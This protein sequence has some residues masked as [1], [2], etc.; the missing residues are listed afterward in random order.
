MMRIIGISLGTGV[1]LFA[2][3][4]WF[5]HQQNPPSNGTGLDTGPL[6][7]GFLALFLL[8]ALGAIFVFRTRVAP[9]IARPPEQDRWQPRA[10]EIQTG[11]I[12]AWGLAE[13]AALFGEVIY[14]LTGFTLAGILGLALIWGAVGLAWPKRAWLQRGAGPT[15]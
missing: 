4:S 1:T 7:Y 11:L 10:S 9:V 8:A 13:G 15:S 6:F 3:V 14:F 5:L 12:L 2:F